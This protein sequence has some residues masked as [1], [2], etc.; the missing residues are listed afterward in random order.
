M[1][2][3]NPLSLS[4]KEDW[5]GNDLALEYRPI[6]MEDQARSLHVHLTVGH[7]AV[8]KFQN[9]SLCHSAKCFLKYLFPV[10]T[11]SLVGSRKHKTGKLQINRQSG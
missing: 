1:I 10:I 4:E 3:K 2:R 11:V 8:R 7:L 5:K 6:A 9:I